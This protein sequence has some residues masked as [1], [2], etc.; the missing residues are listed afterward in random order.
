M[1]GMKAA[2][3]GKKTLIRKMFKSAYTLSLRLVGNSCGRVCYIHERKKTNNNAL[4][5]LC[6]TAN[7]SLPSLSGFF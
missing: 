6:G 5:Y 3:E 7:L 4:T 2:R 1:K